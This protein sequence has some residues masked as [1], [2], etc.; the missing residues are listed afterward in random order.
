MK[1]VFWIKGERGIRC[2][3]QVL[4]EKIAID[5]L[6]LQPQPDTQWF[7]EASRIASAQKIEVIIPEDPNGP[8]SERALRDRDADLFVLA[9]YGK[10][11]RRNILGIPKLMCLNL[12][13][14]RLP[15]NR[16]SSPMN[17]ALIKGQE[18]FGI[19]IIRLSAG[20]DTGDV[21]IERRFPIRESDT[22][23]DLHATANEN[24]P[25][26]LVE[27]LR[28]L[29]D[30]SYQLTPQDAAHAG[31]YPLR[32]PDDGLVLWDML[33]AREIHNRIRA[34]TVPFPCAF[35][36][37]EGRRIHLIASRLRQSPFYG[38]PGRIYLKRKGELL[39]CGKDECLWIT[40]AV[41]A[42]DGL[43]AHE[44]IRRYERLA[45]VQGL[46]ERMIRGDSH[47]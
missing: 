40:E 19:S 13:G 22:I 38:E 12:H 42:K 29:E 46:A 33:T 20:V 17:W 18:A 14:G 36:Y 4:D 35:T 26:M 5:L 44:G 25:E 41:F 21:L 23:R 9:G 8:E 39:V 15:E 34:L 16:G 2:L 37:Y 43:P 32:F 30:G 3:R 11:L 47:R 24:F 45:T 7:Q 1:I 10:I 27:A 28:R 31:Y 6:V